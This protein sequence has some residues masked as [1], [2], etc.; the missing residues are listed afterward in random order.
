MSSEEY[1]DWLAYYQLN[2]FGPYRA[3]VQTANIAR[4]I[5]QVN[6]RK[7]YTAKLEDFIVTFAAPGASKP[8]SPQQIH[9]ALVARFGRKPHG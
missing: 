9:A 5:A 2:P 4:W 7:G 3:D 6:A 8:M 1:A